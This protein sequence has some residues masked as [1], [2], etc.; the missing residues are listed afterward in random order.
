[1]NA[2]LR[3]HLFLMAMSGLAPA[4]SGCITR[5]GLEWEWQRCYPGPTRNCS[6]ISVLLIARDRLP[7]RALSIDNVRVR[8]ATEYHLL[9]GDHVVV[10]QPD[11]R[12]PVAIP[13]ERDSANK[14]YTF[15]GGR[16]G[17]LKG[18][19][20]PMAVSL[21]P[22][23]VYRLTAQLVWEDDG[24]GHLYWRNKRSEWHPRVE[25]MGRFEALKSALARQQQA[26]RSGGQR[27]RDP[28]QAADIPW[29][30]LKLGTLQRAPVHWMPADQGSVKKQPPTQ[31]DAVVH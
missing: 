17:E 12:L 19:P 14:T 23:L 1:M 15:V 29:P 28:T 26:F 22:G 18:E 10:S 27:R 25:C 11:G 21:E 7:L 2:E 5:S 9:P 30:R 20:A 8:A 16:K 24:S 6:D 31:E 13:F 3:V 4:L